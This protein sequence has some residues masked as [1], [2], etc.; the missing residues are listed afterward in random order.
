MQLTVNKPMPRSFAPVSEPSA[1][2]LILGSLPGVRSLQ[3]QQ[4]YAQPRNAFWSIMD[5]ICGA[6]P[7]LPYERRLSQ[8]T[9]SGMA[10]WD[11]VASANRSGSLDSAIVPQSVNTNDFAA[12]FAEHQRIRHIF[13]N[14]LTAEKLYR[15]KVLPQLAPLRTDP[16]MAVLPSTSPAYASMKFA[17]KRKRWM[18]AISPLL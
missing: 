7:Q 6:A 15:Q 10:L 17:E 1:K 9:G 13:F 4:Y 2:I 5:S 14:G 3:D 16:L 8:L 12:F 18:A 11:V